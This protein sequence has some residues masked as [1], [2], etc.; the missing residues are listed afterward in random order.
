MCSWYVERYI[1]YIIPLTTAA[2]QPKNNFA[3]RGIKTSVKEYY[4]H[5][6][7][8]FINI[9]SNCSSSDQ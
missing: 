4:K 6:I 7:K 5:H 9:R 2:K 1:A 3:K 8:P